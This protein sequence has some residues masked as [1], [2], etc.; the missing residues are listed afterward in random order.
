MGHGM[1]FFG[2]FLYILWLLLLRMKAVEKISVKCC[3]IDNIK[4]L[5]VGK[6]HS[7]VQHKKER[8]GRINASLLDRVRQILYAV[9]LLEVAFLGSYIFVAI[10]CC[11]CLL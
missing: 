5:R 2:V 1:L 11:C 9:C 8:N 7:S 10:S 6:V 4:Q 3:F